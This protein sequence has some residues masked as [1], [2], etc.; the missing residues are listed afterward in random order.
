[1]GLLKTGQWQWVATVQVQHA[2]P[3]TKTTVPFSLTRI[4]SRLRRKAKRGQALHPAGTA[5]ASMASTR[6]CTRSPAYS[7][8]CFVRARTVKPP[9]TYGKRGFL[10]NI[11]NHIGTP[12]TRGSVTFEIHQ[13]LVPTNTCLTKGTK[14]S[15]ARPPLLVTSSDRQGQGDKIT[16]A[17]KCTMV[18][19]N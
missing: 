2:A 11:G 9:P 6:T 15:Q 3:A 4:T 19:Q 1:M 5:I 13:P 8:M 17:A 7:R 16:K 10:G 12:L 18:L 14:T